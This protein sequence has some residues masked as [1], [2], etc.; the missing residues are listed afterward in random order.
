MLVLDVGDGGVCVKFFLNGD[1][2]CCVCVGC[3]ENSLCTCVSICGND[4]SEQAIGFDWA[5]WSPT[6]G[7]EQVIV[8]DGAVELGFLKVR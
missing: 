1:D 2:V 7:K 4:C 8:N 6:E 3:L 5:W